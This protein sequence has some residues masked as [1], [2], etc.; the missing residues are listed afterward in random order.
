MSALHD[1]PWQEI[2][3]WIISPSSKQTR[4]KQCSKHDTIY[5]SCEPLIKST[6]VSRQTGSMK[7]LSTSNWK[8]S[9]RADCRHARQYKFRSI[10][11]QFGFRRNN[12]SYTPRSH[13]RPRLVLH[14]SNSCSA[15]ALEVPEIGVLVV[16]MQVWSLAKILWILASAVG[17]SVRLQRAH[18]LGS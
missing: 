12:S 9:H 6:G 8:T 10:P 15:M 11:L 3:F 5:V 13:G 4:V 2:T 17:H 14:F 16:L 1:E 18:I 7:L